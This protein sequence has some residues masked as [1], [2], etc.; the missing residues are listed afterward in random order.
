MSYPIM[1]CK[2]IRV[3]GQGMDELLYQR[4]VLPIPPAHGMG[5]ELRCVGQ[6]ITWINMHRR[7]N[8]EFLPVCWL[9]D[10]RTI[11]EKYD[12]TL[13]QMKQALSERVDWYKEKGWKLIS[14]NLEAWS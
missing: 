3:G 5:L 13:P 1:V 14:E 8:G 10:D 11:R 9:D 6:T 4:V 12:L 2:W 7:D